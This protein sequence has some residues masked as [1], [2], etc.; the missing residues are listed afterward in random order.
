MRCLCQ[1]VINILQ[2]LENISFRWLNS[3]SLKLL[4]IKRGEVFLNE[5]IF[6]N[7]VDM[8]SH[9]P[10]HTFD[11]SFCIGKVVYENSFFLLIVLKIG[12]RCFSS[13]R[14]LLTSSTS[15]FGL[16]LFTHSSWFGCI[17]KIRVFKVYVFL[18]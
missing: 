16:L 12:F 8:L 14:S 1:P 15:F 6:L 2:F 4:F 17:R 10:K 11:L 3:C 7:G 18:F 5:E 9:H 13:V